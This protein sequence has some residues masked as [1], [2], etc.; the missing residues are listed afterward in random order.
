MVNDGQVGTRSTP[1]QQLAKWLVSG[2]LS[3]LLTH[4]QARDTLREAAR[5][6]SCF[7]PVVQKMTAHFG[8]LSV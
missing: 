5:G 4:G 7:N 1:I 2:A 6:L 8:M 3:V